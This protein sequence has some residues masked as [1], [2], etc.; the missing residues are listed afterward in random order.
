MFCAPDKKF[1]IYVHGMRA[2]NLREV[3]K[4]ANGDAHDR[5]KITVYLITEETNGHM[6]YMTIPFGD[7]LNELP[8]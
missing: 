2:S 6:S 7:L 3:L 1:E 4:Y 5:S 8:L